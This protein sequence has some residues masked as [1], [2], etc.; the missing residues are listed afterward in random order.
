MLLSRTVAGALGERLGWRA[1]YLVAAGLTLLTAALLARVLPATRPPSGQRYPALLAESAG[2]LRA[3]PE[4]RRSCLYQTAVFTGFSAV[5]AAVALLFTGPTY[6]L[7]TPAVGTLAL[8]N[9]V[10]MVSTPVA[11]RQ[12][13]RRGS[14]A[15]NI[16]CLVAVIAAAA[17]LAAGGLGGAVGLAAVVAGTLLLDVAMQAGMA[18]NQVRLYALRPQVRNRLNTVYMTCAYLGGSLGSWLGVRTYG[19]FGWPALCGL[20]ALLAVPALAH[21]LLRR[22]T[23][24]PAGAPWSSTPRSPVPAVTVVDAPGPGRR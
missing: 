17:V 18:A 5:W 20:V 13:D 22:A 9:A 21:L 14:D 1:L 7:G 16:A 8:V 4:L 2:L 10:T 12:V 23:I 24:R 3:E 11:G 6:H 19:R 15:V